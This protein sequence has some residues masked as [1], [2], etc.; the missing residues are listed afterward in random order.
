[1]KERNQ[2]A[3]QRKAENKEKVENFKSAVKA[4]NGLACNDA[5]AIKEKYLSCNDYYVNN[6]A[7]GRGSG[8]TSPQQT[9]T[10]PE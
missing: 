6:R 5:M 1:M 8:V 3:K 10:R 4:I 7:M 9:G 2:I